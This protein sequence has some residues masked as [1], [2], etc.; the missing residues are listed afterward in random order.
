MRTDSKAWGAALDTLIRA[1]IDSF[2][3]SS[4]RMLDSTPTMIYESSV[5]TPGTFDCEVTGG[6]LRCIV[7]ASRKPKPAVERFEKLVQIV[8][9]WL[10]VGWTSIERTETTAGDRTFLAQDGMNGTLLTLALRA[11]QVYFLAKRSPV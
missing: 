10:P 3:S 6:A 9:D 8:R 7:F 11:T 4:G 5:G 1:A 2:A